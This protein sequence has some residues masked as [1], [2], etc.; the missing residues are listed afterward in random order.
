MEVDDMW[1]DEEDLAPF[2]PK[3][4]T[5]SLPESPTMSTEQLPPEIEMAI[6]DL[7][8]AG[9]YNRAPTFV[10]HAKEA[11]R[12]AIAA[13]SARKEG[14]VRPVAQRVPN[15]HGRHDY[16]DFGET[17]NAEL[18]PEPLYTHPAPQGA[19]ASQAEQAAMYRELRRDFSPMGMNADGQ[20]AW[21]Y[22]R[23]A[24]LKG[25]T[26]DDALRTAMKGDAS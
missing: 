7:E 22:R 13:Y 2:T 14:A 23:N 3:Q 1:D 8:Y 18:N 15:E 26:L 25:P 10:A 11:L 19:D 17:Y 21:V 4:P 5:R 16:W 20:H 6:R 9:R 24:T 12:A